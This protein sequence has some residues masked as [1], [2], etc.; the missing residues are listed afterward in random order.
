MALQ[1]NPVL[2]DGPTDQLVDGIVSADILADSEQL[3]V[4]GEQTGCV[5]AAGG[6]EDLLRGPEPSRAARSDVGPDPERVVGGPVAA[7]VAGS[8][9]SEALPHT[10][11]EEVV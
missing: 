1:G 8:A 3:P 7:C 10:P 9:S 11:H 2:L 5:Q 6:V 4:G